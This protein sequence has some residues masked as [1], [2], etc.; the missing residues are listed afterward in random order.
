MDCHFAM[1]SCSTINFLTSSNLKNE[2]TQDYIYKWFCIFNGITHP[3]H[4]LRA[5]M[6]QKIM[7][8]S[9]GPRYNK[10]NNYIYYFKDLRYNLKKNTFQ[11]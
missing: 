10:F 8:E 7:I 3:F 11:F 1:K 5:K 9:P 4:L 6:T 2:I